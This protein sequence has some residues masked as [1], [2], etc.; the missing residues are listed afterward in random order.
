MLF[1]AQIITALL[2]WLVGLYL[3]PQLGLYL[4]IWWWDIP[5]HFLGGLWAGFLGAWFF[6]N[7]KRRLSVL[8]CALFAFGVGI[9]WE[10]FEYTNGVGGSVGPFMGYWADTIK[11]LVFD[12]I[13]GVTAGTIA[14]YERPWLK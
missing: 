7:W 1:W 5:A 2:A 13:G 14:K 10:I 12:V 9:L 6:F 11:D 3:G 4:S 8:E